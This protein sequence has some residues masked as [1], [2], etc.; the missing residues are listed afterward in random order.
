MSIAPLAEQAG[1]LVLSPSSSNPDIEEL[2]GFIFS[3]SYSDK[4]TGEDLAKEMKGYKRIALI[5]EQNEYNIGIRDALL[6]NIK[7]Y[8]T[9]VVVAN[10]TFP[11]GATDFRAVLEK[12]RQTNPDAILL[13]PNPG[14]TSQNLIRQ[15]AEIKGWAGYKLFGQTAYLIDS[16]RAP[17]GDFAEGMIIIDAPNANSDALNAEKDLAL[18]DLGGTFDNI[19]N[20]YTATSFDA[21]NLLLGLI[22]K[23]G[24]DAAKVKDELSI[25]KF[26]GFIGD[27]QFDGHNFVQLNISGKYIVQGGKA[28]FQK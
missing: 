22:V 25:G 24:D 19:G 1:V 27:I 8:P 12:V 11:K 23:N 18:K 28:V 10:E 26:S 16:G 20:Y 7:N 13:N 5:N 15:L 4:K 2:G 3:L 6:E 17:A 14:V 21:P 9:A